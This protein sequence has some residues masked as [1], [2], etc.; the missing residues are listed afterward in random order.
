MPFYVVKIGPPT[1]PSVQNPVSTVYYATNT[2]G[3]SESYTSANG[4]TADKASLEANLQTLVTN[5]MNNPTLPFTFQSTTVTPPI[6]TGWGCISTATPCSGDNQDDLFDEDL[7]N[8]QVENLNDVVIVAGVNHVLTDKALY[9]GHSI[10]D[11]ENNGGVLGITYPAVDQA[12]SLSNA[13]ANYFGIPAGATAQEKL[14]LARL[15]QGLYAYAI[16]Y[17]C[18]GLQYCSNIP[19]PTATNPVGLAPGAPFTVASRVYV[20]PVRLT[21]PLTTF[22][23]PNRSETVDHQ[24]LLGTHK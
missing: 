22:V 13:G 6:H 20:D 9:I 5:I 11:P 14:R 16:S 8:V 7:Q 4:T 10:Y 23:R 12:P 1:K 17:D 21:E 15:Y 3:I 19:A 18:T 24:I 2:T